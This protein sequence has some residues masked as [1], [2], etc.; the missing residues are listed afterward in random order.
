MNALWLILLSAAVSGGAA[1]LVSLRFHPWWPCRA[2]KGTG[3]TRDRIWKPARGT[4]SA[5]G[6]KGQR[7][8]LGIRVLDPDRAQAMTPPK[9]TRRRADKREPR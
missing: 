6:G 3:K 5:C 9:G 2:C 7:P 4:C 8:R 1:Y